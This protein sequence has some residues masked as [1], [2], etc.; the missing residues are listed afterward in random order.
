MDFLC[1]MTWKDDVRDEYLSEVIIQ[2]FSL[3]TSVMLENF[4]NQ[5]V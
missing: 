4:A 3:L 5:V 2:H 1:E